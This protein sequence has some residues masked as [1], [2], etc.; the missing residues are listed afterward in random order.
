VVVFVH[1]EVRSRSCGNA[2]VRRIMLGSGRWKLNVPHALI[3]T[4]PPGLHATARGWSEQLADYDAWKRGFHAHFDA[5]R[6]EGVGVTL[7]AVYRDADDPT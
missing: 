1:D 2:V 5:A 4:R 6:M 7:E 3:V